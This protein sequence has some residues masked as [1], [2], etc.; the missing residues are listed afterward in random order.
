V[1]GSG[2]YEITRL[3]GALALPA[4]LGL[5]FVGCGDD[6]DDDGA[7]GGSGGGSD[8]EFVADICGAMLTFSKD[9]QKLLSDPKTLE[10]EDEAVKA[11][12]KPFETL[13]NAFEDAD[14][15]S[16]LRDWHRTASS[17]LNKAAE[18]FKDGDASAL[19]EF[20]DAPIPEAPAAA[21]DR[22]Q[23]IA[24]S[25]KDCQDADFSLGGEN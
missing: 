4:A 20:E 10:D 12:A 8:E 19:E 1:E 11:L 17:E 23:K 24:D 2:E 25:N 9:V 14:P 5:A 21:Q 6:D 15:P 18:S 22:L 3:V 16:D 7:I 13:A